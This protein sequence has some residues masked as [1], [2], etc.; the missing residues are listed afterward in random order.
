[1]QYK[2]RKIIKFNYKGDNYQLF[3]DS[4]GRLAF[5]K[6][7]KDNNYRYPELERL[8]ELTSLFVDT[9]DIAHIKRESK[10]Y[11]FIPK[12][13]VA[14]VVCALSLA[15]LTGCANHYNQSDFDKYLENQPSVNVT[16]DQNGNQND[17]NIDFD[18]DEEEKDYSK[19]K[20]NGSGVPDKLSQEVIDKYISYLAPADDQ[21]D[22]R[23]ESD[24]QY[25]NLVKIEKGR[26]QS[27]NEQI[28]GYEDVTLEQIKEAVNKNPNISKKYKDFIYQFACDLRTLYPNVNLAVLYHNLETLV[29]DELTQSQMNKETMST[30]S[31]ACYIRTENRICVLEDLDL[32]KESDDYIIFAHELCHAAR[33]ANF[34]NDKGFQVYVSYFDYYR[35]G[36]YAEE[37]I[38]TNIVYD[39]QGLGKRADFYPMQSSYY[40]IIMDATGYTGEDFFNHSVNYLIDKMDAFMGDEDYA[41]QIVAAIDAQASLRY[42]SYAA[43]DFYDFQIV[44]DYIAEM[45]FKKHITPDMSYSEAEVVFDEFYDNITHY[46][47][48]MNRKYTINE[49]TFRPVFE[50]YVSGLGIQ[51]G[52]SLN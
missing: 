48:N 47:E 29:I 11:S 51:K 40:R 32:S 50:E 10:F 43:V 33:S 18:L 45:Y 44:H 36:T 23:Y 19:E 41:W 24:Y 25:Y 12:V 46:F 35:M 38:I 42:T 7:D 26:D 20:Y 3:K 5:L 13:K 14:G 21:Y 34:T 9:R 1:M 4:F 16:Q 27:A 30:D 28:F 31:A 2:F 17:V 15:F 22:Y 37:G 8:F 6:I 39:L 49:D 52:R